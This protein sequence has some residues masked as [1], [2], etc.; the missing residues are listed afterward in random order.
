MARGSR[1]G[2]R[3]T[4]K[5]R[6]AWIGAVV[7]ALVATLT[8]VAPAAQAEAAIVADTDPREGWRPNSERDEGN[9]ATEPP[10]AAPG[11]IALDRSLGARPSHWK[12]AGAAHG[13]RL[14]APKSPRATGADLSWGAYPGDDLREYQVHRATRKDFA[15]SAETL[16][17][18]VPATTHQYRD[19]SAPPAAEGRGT[20]YHY[21]VVALLEDGRL[22]D[23]PARTLRLPL[24]SDLLK[25]PTGE[26]PEDERDPQD[27][28]ADGTYYLPATPARAVPGERQ[29]V[30]ATL[31]NT[32]DEVWKADEKALSY[33]WSLGGHDVS[34]PVNQKPTGLPRDVRPGESVTFDARLAIPKLGNLLA[35]R[36][37]YDLDWDLRDRRTHS[38]L[39]RTDDVPPSSH[40]V[41]VE[42]ATSNRLGLEKF[43]S[44][45][46]Q[47]TGANSTVMGNLASGNA[48]W[49][50]NAFNNPS[51][52]FNSFARLSYNSQDFS[53]GPA[54]RGWSLQLSSPLR[55]GSPL[56]F[57][58]LRAL[59]L[60]VFMTDGDGT[61]HVFR[62]DLKKHEWRAPAGVHLKLRKL[63][64]TCLPLLSHE[65]EAWEMVRPDRTRFLYDCQGY[66]TAM[67]DKNGNRMEFTYK[68]K[69]LGLLGKE[70]QY[71]TDADG[72]RT[73]T[74]DYWDKFEP[75]RYVDGDGRV[76]EGR[77][78]VNPH[79]AGKVKSVTDV[80]GRRMDLTYT[81]H[82]Q[83]ARVAD[84]A[85][86]AQP[87]VFAF[88]YGKAWGLPFHKLDKVTDPRGNSTKLAYVT[89][90]DKDQ[91]HYLGNLKH[92][93]DR[94][95]ATTRY[96]YEDP[97]G[98]KG[99]TTR[100]VV[101]DAEGNPGTQVLDGYGRPVRMTDAKRH[102][103]TLGWDAQNN[104]TRLE[105]ANGAVTTWKYDPKTGYPLEMRD[106]EA[107]KNGRPAARFG[108]AT[109]ED[110]HIAE[111][112][113][114][115]SPE[116]RKWRFGQ[117]ARGNLTS[118]TDPKGVESDADGDYTTTH[119]YD[120][121]G[122]LTA[123]TDAGGH[124]TRFADYHPSGFPTVT[125]DPLGN[126]TTNA[127][128]ARGNVTALRE[129]NGATT[130]QT[131]DV[132]GRPLEN[133]KPKDEQ[134]GEYLTTPAPEYD[135][136]DN[137][138]TFTAPNNVSSHST[139]D[140]ADR[141]V[142]QE[143]PRDEPDGPRRQVTYTYDKVGNQLT[144]TEPRGNL[145]DDPDDFTTTTRYDELNQPV[146]ITDAEGGRTTSAYDSVG[147]LARVTD[148]RKNQNDDPDDYTSR[149]G[150][151]LNKQL[152][153]STDAKGES[154]GTVYDWDGQKTATTDA[155]GNRVTQLLDARG[156]VVENQ[157][158]H[159]RSG[160]D[161]KYNRTRFEYDEVG[162]QTKE[163]TPRGVN[164][165]GKPDDFASQTVYDELNR[166]KETR[167]PYDPGD[168]TYNKPD[169]TSYSYDEVG[170][171]T[172]VSAPPSEG[173]NVR[174]DTTYSYFDNGWT[175]KSTDPHGIVSSYEY[176]KLGQ[177]IQTTLTSA[178]GSVSRTMDTAF[179]PS[180]A[181]KSRSDDGVPVG[182]D[183][184][185]VDNSDTNNTAEQG[186]WTASRPDKAYGYNTH[187]HPRGDGRA[188]FAWQLN[189]PRNGTYEVFT[190]NPKTEGAATDA[191]YEIEHKDGKAK[192]QVDQSANP[193]K[194]RSLGSYSFTEGGK[195]AV[196]VTDKANGTVLADAVRLVRDNS[197]DTDRESKDFT[198]RYDANGNRTEVTDNSPGARTDRHTMSYDGVN[199]LTEVQ[200]RA[201]GDVRD[202][203]RLTYDANG[204]TLTTKHDLTW[205]KLEYDAL[206]RVSE[207]T[208]ADSPDAG[209]Q[210]V[211]RVSYTDRGEL[212]R[213]VK[214]NGNVATYD[215]YLDG[216]TR[217]QTEK[218]DDGRTVAQ[219][220][221]S[222]NA[223]GHKTKDVLRLMDADGGGTKDNTY[224]YAYDP[225]DRISR[226]D[227]SGDSDA[228]ERYEHD[229]AGNVVEQ[230]TDGTTT[231]HSYDRN[232]LLSSTA[233]GVSSTYNYDPLGRLDTV[234]SAGETVTKHRYDGFDR[235]ASTTTGTGDAARTKTFSYDAFDRTIR[236]HTDGDDPKTKN[237][238]YLGITSKELR[239]Q[240]E[241]GDTN[242]FQYAPWGQKLTQVKKPDGKDEET[243][244]Y[245]Y[246]PHGD[247][248]ALTERDGTTKS[249]YGYT[250]YGQNDQ[251]QFSGADKPDED[252]QEKEDPYNSYRYNSMRY[253]TASGDYD[254]GFRNYDPGLN[255]FLTRDMYGG[256]LADM[257][258]TTDPFTGNRYA[259]AGGNPVSFVE[260]DGHL[261]GLSWSDIG[262]GA[263]DVAG[264]IPVV[265]EV[266]DLG[267]C[268]WYGAEG[269]ATDAALSC[270]GAIPF[271][272]W[273]AAGTK[274][275]KYG[276]KAWD[277]LSGGK[278]ADNAGDAA[279]NAGKANGG[280]GNGGNGNGGGNN[281]GGNNGGGNNGG[282]NNGGNGNGG[283][284]NG[285]SNNGGNSNGGSNNGGGNNGGGSNGGSGN[286]GG[287]SGGSTG[288][289]AA[290]PAPAKQAK[291]EG[292]A[293]S[294]GACK[295]NSFVGGTRVLMA[296]GSAV[297]IEDV[298]KGDRVAATDVETEHA[299]TRRVT[300]TITGEGTKKLVEITVTGDDRGTDR[301]GTDKLTATE[302]HPFWVPDVGRW[303]DAGE[304]RPGQ[305]LRTGSGTWTQV[306][307]VEH[308][309][310]TER[311]HNLTVEGQQTYYVVAGDT[312]LLVHNATPASAPVPS[313]PAGVVYLRTDIATGAEY[314]GQAKSWGRYVAR[315]Q[316]HNRK[317][318]GAGYN[319]EVLGRAN[320]GQ[321]L[322]VLEEDW[323]RAGGGKSSVPGSVLENK[324]VQMNDARYKGAGGS[325]C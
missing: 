235:K 287:S 294:G 109:G 17:A 192:R 230:T 176:N 38:W 86:S 177:Q 318:G 73:M 257:S 14:D 34:N 2:L 311:V 162:N 201:G 19:R 173:Q 263:L 41:V 163:I 250:A 265:G 259:F 83:L 268:A 266:A 306:E 155:D 119:A 193:G 15:P 260:I 252:G 85:G 223:N 157:V 16:V 315:M 30:E 208:N 78:L 190:R 319:F 88:D 239:E 189:I 60:K 154:T 139:Y 195:H 228:A 68:K 70:L 28:A 74:V 128:D 3:A 4:G 202:T 183:A 114:R 165:P 300:G 81:Q 211:T 320:P 234:S 156:K 310:R 100:S 5:L 204:N 323:M 104:V 285:G 281:G 242:S 72:R 33:R 53:S 172:K 50:Y 164:T 96:S 222:Y 224:D 47:N 296:D 89:P 127:Y 225:Q 80:S 286:G 97:D 87:K 120:D 191:T 280:N 194:W 324:R 1:P 132:F 153:T 125:T 91:R 186:D 98:H 298:K 316:E 22:L 20:T 63:A 301:H 116:G 8:G 232:R 10:A 140:A 27:P 75:Y 276:G 215:Y 67:V 251:E 137:T 29:T 312:P 171:V 37:T 90:H 32:T 314:V 66:P 305:W 209:D 147:N 95:G 39:S 213:Q 144:E 273:G 297:P 246:H 65:R 196:T 49:S 325:V 82:G 181:M 304:L 290:A 110:G 35:S 288:G 124:T 7:T 45:S 277:A 226:V 237:F 161:I 203:T 6:T 321:A 210:Q 198:Y 94:L 295:V 264:L 55:L 175:K 25:P 218:T 303:V 143:K 307:A 199:R 206:D 299:S 243:A 240:T 54:G 159:S 107:V 283:G 258:L 92:V 241:G 272:G 255:R 185:L 267:N 231:R 121:A 182:L 179:Y 167:T 309:E 21:K 31:T 44:Y 71:V 84:G 254:M 270:A 261:F 43:Q 170:N 187:S 184:V 244:Q 106:P 56:Q 247:V 134:A 48:V 289:P 117:D 178:G 219:H 150:Y 122:R 18:P 118:V 158:P 207:V 113:G 302:G 133:Q 26:E 46:G 322:D 23:S 229:A 269:N 180:G 102:T 160:D 212:A 248:E 62:K 58:P 105:E 249:T 168:A 115:I 52:G 279:G 123:T 262:H 24:L 135:A 308:T 152:V 227:K 278:K 291:P 146:R 61:T 126:R 57:S 216:A 77:L 142:A 271:V 217:Q 149:Y 108:Y 245:V 64:K 129:A 76:R 11:G 214:P 151:D 59:P 317:R 131:Y 9:W 274:F 233:D 79:I 284:N 12:V 42:R 256:A 282:S 13:L 205:S 40:E 166:V 51:R 253:D 174:N 292:D 36:V 293:P 236:E 112:A 99:R 313:A 221:L 188:R 69:L 220:R 145:T 169:R 148:P 103:T 275:A 136:N 130:T 111:L 238:T 141:L 93:T 197:G 101:T 200:E 138:V